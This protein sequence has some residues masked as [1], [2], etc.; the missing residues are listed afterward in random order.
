V[1][2]PIAAVPG[3]GT[4]QLS[5]AKAAALQDVNSALDGLRT[6]QQSGNFA[7]YGEA[8]QKLDDAVAKYQNAK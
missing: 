8:L 3:G 5:A 6:A 7:A 1:P 4:V 2:T